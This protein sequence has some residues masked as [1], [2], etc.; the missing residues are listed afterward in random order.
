MSVRSLVACRLFSYIGQRKFRHAVEFSRQVHM[1]NPIRLTVNGQTRLIEAAADTPLLYVLRNDLRLNGPQF[2]C[3]RE[4]C[5][6]C[7]V[8]VGAKAVMSCRLPISEVSS[9]AIT[10]LE[11][12]SQAG[13]LHP[14]QQAFI[15]QQAAQCGY[16]S[17]GMIISAAAL[18]WKAPHPTE[19]QVRAA[20]DGNLCRCGSHVRILRAVRRAAELLAAESA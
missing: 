11:G 7:M 1:D 16:C 13:E 4:S 14:V 19:T 20:L 2:G 8:L 9:A 3:G 15:E 6:A 5:G 17:N 12:L 18:L 10:T